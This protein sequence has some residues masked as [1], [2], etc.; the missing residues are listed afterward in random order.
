M[1]ATAA[2]KRA[3]LIL[4]IFAGLVVFPATM[5]VMGKKA[6]LQRSYYG[7]VIYPAKKAYD[8]SLTDQD[9]RPFQL[10]DLL[11]KVVVFSFGFAHCP[12]IC[13]MTL[14]DLSSFYKQLPEKD[15]PRVRVLFI[16]IDPER[17]TPD[18]L[19]NFVPFFNPAFTGLTGTPDQI[20]RTAKEY[21]A[22]YE[23]VDQYSNDT[24]QLYTMNHSAYV[25]VIDPS[26]NFKLLYNYEQLMDGKR[27]A[28]DIEN[29]LHAA[30]QEK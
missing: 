26:G 2:R 24:S 6:A 4:F 23:K 9:G 29:L 30:G 28:D 10:H 1:I 22:F 5:Y 7:Q 3:F 21:G 19:K 18:K 20:A 17:D 11:G 13:P 25:Y 15:Q 8:F 14:G 16:S 27:I 12:N